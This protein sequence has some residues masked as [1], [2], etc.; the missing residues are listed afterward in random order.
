[1]FVTIHYLNASGQPASV[2]STAFSY[3]QKNSTQGFQTFINPYM[4]PGDARWAEIELG[5]A[6]NG[7]ATSITFDAYNLR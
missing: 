2:P 3:F 5:A 6:R 4:T 7:L 1:V